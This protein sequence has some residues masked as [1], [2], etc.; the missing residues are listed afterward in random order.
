MPAHHEVAPVPPEELLEA[1][2]GFRL[3]RNGVQEMRGDLVHPLAVPNRGV[4]ER[5]GLEDVCQPIGLR[6]APR[7]LVRRRDGLDGL[8][9]R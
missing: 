3:V 4:E 9:P 8:Q 5:V 2:E 1:P 6:G 7:G